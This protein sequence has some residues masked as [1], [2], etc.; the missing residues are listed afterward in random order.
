M[1]LV[2]LPKFEFTL[3]GEYS[4]VALRYLRLLCQIPDFVAEHVSLGID[5][6]VYGPYVITSNVRV[7]RKAL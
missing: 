6:P 2:G 5:V 4:S 1:K 7:V 3:M